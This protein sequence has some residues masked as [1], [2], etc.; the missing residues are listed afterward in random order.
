MNLCHNLV[1]KLI[2]FATSNALT[3]FGKHCCK[4]AVT[5][6]TEVL[7]KTFIHIMAIWNFSETFFK[8]SKNIHNLLLGAEQDPYPLQ[9]ESLIE[10]I[11]VITTF[12]SSKQLTKIK[13][14]SLNTRRM[15]ILR[16]SRCCFS[17]ILNP[18]STKKLYLTI[19]NE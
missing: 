7:L 4:T 6:K 15:K 8:D 12:D 1:K 14:P 3:E 18:T 10:Q 16:Y 11:K 17:A 19:N 5:A 9:T 13:I 2:L